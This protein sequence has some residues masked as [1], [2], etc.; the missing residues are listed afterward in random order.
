M[1]IKY[2]DDYYKRDITSNAPS[3]FSWWCM[4]EYLCNGMKL[5]D[6]G[7]GNCRDAEF[8]SK[9]NLFVY[10]LDQ[11][12][13]AIVYEIQRINNNNNIKLFESDF[14]DMS[15]DFTDNIDVF[16][17][18]FTMHS[19]NSKQEQ[20]LLNNVYS[21]LNTG[22][23]FLIEAR[24]VNDN[25]FG[26]GEKIG[27]NEF[28]TDHYRRF[29]NMDDFLKDSESIGYKVHYTKESAGLSIVG[30]DDPVLMRVVL[31]K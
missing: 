2:W 24:T 28:F 19:I 9:N 21:K 16:Y 1:D 14:T 3:S 20:R 22:G 10:A 17:S 8:F 12:H 4:E 5:V 29:I 31:V 26:V 27:E 13:E 7:A 15:F 23:L 11:S 25:M 18:R 6:L 30:G